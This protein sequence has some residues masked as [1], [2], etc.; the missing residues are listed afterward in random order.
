[1]CQVNLSSVFLLEYLVSKWFI[2]QITPTKSYMEFT[3]C[4]ENE[5]TATIKNLIVAGVFLNHLGL[6]LCAVLKFS[7]TES[8]T[9]PTK[10]LIQPS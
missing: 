3:S 9:I 2:L 8:N 7:I 6:E 10:P 1:M 5:K 4:C